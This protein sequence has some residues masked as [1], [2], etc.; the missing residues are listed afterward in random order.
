MGI[1]R[2]TKSVNTLL[3][4]FNRKKDAFSVVELVKQLDLYMNKT[5]VYRILERLENEGILHSFMGKDGLK[6]Y[7]KCT[8]CSS[9]NHN[10]VHPHFQ[11]NSCG[12][13]ECLILEIT[14]PKMANYEVESASLLLIGKCQN[15][16]N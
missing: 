12:K 4:V 7:A 11:C 2:K 5:T 3:E 6:W 1:S 10:D 13:T 14:I 15:C 9:D 16:I 8:G